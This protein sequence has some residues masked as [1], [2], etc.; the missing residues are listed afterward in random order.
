M[1]KMSGCFK[2]G[3]FPA[4]MF[5]WNSGVWLKLPQQAQGIFSCKGYTFRNAYVINLT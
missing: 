2:Q 3:I 4:D 5:V 1:K